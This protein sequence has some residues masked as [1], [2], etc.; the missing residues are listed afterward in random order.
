MLFPFSIKYQKRLKG[1][2][3]QDDRI[4]TMNYIEFF[5]RERKGDVLS[6][7]EAELN[8]KSSLFRG[9]SLDIL[10]P[11]E[12]GK[13]RIIQKNENMVLTYEF[14]MYRLFII[15]TIISVAVGLGTKE[16]NLGIIAFF[17]LGIVNWLIALIRH[18]IMLVDITKEIDS[19]N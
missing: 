6:T 10:G 13:F 8:F 12:K 15:A 11:I 16:L 17:W 1:K 18:R 5:I 9:H 4:S 19:N 14:F 3:T 2:L 7:T